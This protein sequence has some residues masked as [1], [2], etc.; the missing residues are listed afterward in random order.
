MRFRICL[1]L[2]KSLVAERRQ[3]FAADSE[4]G[5]SSW[6]YSSSSPASTPSRVAST[7]SR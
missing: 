2:G 7:R 1:A 6:T 3:H 4:I 5:L